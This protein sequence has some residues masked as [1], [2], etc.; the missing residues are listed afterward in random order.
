MTLAP[1]V[2][3]VECKTAES[4]RSIDGHEGWH[5]EF[6]DT[7]YGEVIHLFLSD[8]PSAQ[9]RWRDL[10]I[11]LENADGLVGRSFLV[12]I[13]IK[14]WNSKIH[15]TITEFLCEVLP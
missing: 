9:W 3:V 15:N 5:M 12:T 8:D 10:L 13:A 7:R 6:C 14:E 2:Y 11:F 4:Y 1:G